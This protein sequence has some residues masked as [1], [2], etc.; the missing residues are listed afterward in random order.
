MVETQY[1][2]GIKVFSNQIKFSH[3]PLLKFI[4]DFWKFFGLTHASCCGLTET[5][6]TEAVVSE[7]LET[8][9]SSWVMENSGS[10]KTSGCS[11]TQGGTTRA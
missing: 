9:E 3:Q 11:S 4:F 2:E 10:L 6:I 8:V 7:R 5:S 1:T